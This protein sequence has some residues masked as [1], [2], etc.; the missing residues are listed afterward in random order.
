MIYISKCKFFYRL[1]NLFE[2]IY[3]QILYK[4]GFYFTVNDCYV[5]NVGNLGITITFYF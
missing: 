4:I 3:H 1:M 2:V 5:I